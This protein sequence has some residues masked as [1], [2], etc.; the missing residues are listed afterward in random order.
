MKE[1][2]KEEL[3]YS[4]V[5][6]HRIK[7]DLVNSPIWKIAYKKAELTKEVMEKHKGRMYE[8]TIKFDG[9]TPVQHTNTKE[10]K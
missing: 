1:K 2:L 3:V 4:P 7:A 10:L 8:Y 9:V 5:N 6:D